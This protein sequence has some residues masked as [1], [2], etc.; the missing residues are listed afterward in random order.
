MSKTHISK[1]SCLARR[2]KA[3]VHKARLLKF[4]NHKLGDDT[5]I[6]NMGSALDCPS[7]K[8]GMCE[9]VNKGYRCYAEKPEIQYPR[10]VRRARL[11]QQDDWRSTGSD[12]L[13][14]RF[15]KKIKRRRKET[16]Y[17]RFN[18]AGDF[19]DQSDVEKLSFIADGLKTINVVTYG[20]TSRKDL[21]FRDAKFIVKGSGFTPRG[22]NGRTTVIPRREP[23][24]NGYVL[25]PGNC[26]K[27]QI[28]KV[29]Y[30]FNVAF[31][32]H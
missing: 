12:E 5:A 17:L 26:R 13:L 8:L 7:R 1:Q 4:G 11:T 32:V 28:C 27:C 22:G 25:C 16:R 18:E 21:D 9:V 19:H 15:Y 29:E 20:Y 10:T 14:Q 3:L 6:F 24:P 2:A 23:V 30:P 31:H